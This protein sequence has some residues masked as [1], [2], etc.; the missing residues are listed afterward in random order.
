LDAQETNL[1]DNNGVSFVLEA[2]AELTFDSSRSLEQ[3][4]TGK[5]ATSPDSEHTSLWFDMTVDLLYL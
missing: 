5:H 3:N 1:I 2:F 4:S